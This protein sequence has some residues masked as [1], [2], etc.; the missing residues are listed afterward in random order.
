MKILAIGDFHGKFPSK[1]KKEANK[2]DLVFSIGDFGGSDRLLKIIFKYFYMGWHNYVGK[3]KAKELV[4]EDYNSG[5]RVIGELNKLKVPVYTIHGNWDFEDKKYSQRTAGLKLKKYSELIK[6]KKNIHFLKNR[7]I[8]LKGLKLRAFG[9]NVTASAYL[10]D[11]KIFERKKIEK[12][13]KKN[14][15]ER[16]QLFKLK[17]KN[18]DILLAHYPP[19][20]YFDIVKF[21]GENPM[22]GKHVGFK[23]YTEYIKKYQPRLFICGHM[24][25]Y[26]GKKKLGK[27][28]IIT[29]GSAKEGKAALIEFSEDKKKNI[30]IKFIK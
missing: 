8:N 7:L 19:H 25:E 4:M 29:I 24:H 20:G 2:A 30:K 10:I 26:Q 15:R 27:T 18:I 5:K 6:N 1:L 9:G 28:T 13:K 21:K 23:P 16:K 3:K 14:L 17:D 22:N 11:K 12:F